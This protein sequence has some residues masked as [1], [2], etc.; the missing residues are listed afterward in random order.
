MRGAAPSARSPGARFGL[1]VL[2][3][4]L[5]AV[6]LFAVYL[7][8]YDRQSQSETARGSITEGWGQPQRF[9]GPFLVIPFSQTVQSDGMEEGRSVRRLQRMERALFIAPTE[10]AFETTLDPEV[11]RRSIYRAVVY[12]AAMR[13]TGSFRLPDLASLNIDPA[14][15]RMADAEI[16]FGI[17]SA[18]G[19][20]GSR[21]LVR[22]A[23]R[24][25]PLIPGSAL[26][27]TERSGFSGRTGPLPAGPIPFDIAFT[28][29][30]HDSLTLLPGA[31]DTRWRVSSRWPHPS[32]V[33]GFLPVARQ[34]G[35]SGFAA[36]WRIGN[37]AL[38]RPT[39]S[40]DEQNSDAADQVTVALIDPVDL[41]AE[42]NRAVKY[43]F[44]FIG[45]TFLMLL[46]F[47]VIGGVPV[48]GVAYLLVGVGL[49]LFFV[50]LLA[51]AEIVGFTLA[52]LIA[53]AAIVALVSAYA[54]AVLGG[55]RRAGAV[56]GML[57]GLYATLYVL[58][59]LEA[60]AL[61]IGALLM[62]AALAAVMY[63]TRNVD[64]RRVVRPGEDAASTPAA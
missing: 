24:V 22:V 44:M 40:I 6:P 11:R 53:A 59:S 52:Y 43:G 15:V 28:M 61:L 32:F 26:N 63:F 33:G 10:V 20:G 60:F 50:L 14:S 54:A 21:P 29:R 12:A 47:D 23:G 4:L 7:L 18:K 39:V 35:A 45:F 19:L 16:R 46:M 51:L 58:L 17:S 38:N 49:I 57:S 37:L 25:V 31:Q 36:E 3:G 41:Y 62:F 48:A 9:A 1:T 8:V 30:G 27:A 13:A 56:A 55:W 34:V 64:W 5:L 2:L 42:V